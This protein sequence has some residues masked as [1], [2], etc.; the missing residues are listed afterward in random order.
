LNG[1]SENSCLPEKAPGGS[2]LCSSG[3][4]ATV[5]L[6]EIPGT[7]G[8]SVSG[9]KLPLI[10]GVAGLQLYLVYLNNQERENGSLKNIDLYDQ[11][12]AP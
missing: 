11:K 3:K 2:Y 10:F 7:F 9:E 6:Q 1:N 4:L 8:P 5:Q 12:T